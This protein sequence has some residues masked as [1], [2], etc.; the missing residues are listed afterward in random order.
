MKK[1]NNSQSPINLATFENSTAFSPK[2]AQGHIIKLQT[3]TPPLILSHKKL[4]SEDWYSDLCISSPTPFS[5][6]RKM[7]FKTYFPLLFPADQLLSVGTCLRDFRSGFASELF[8]EFVQMGLVVPAYMTAREGMTS[9]YPERDIPSRPSPRCKE[10]TGPALY[11]IFRNLCANLQ[12][13]SRG[14]IQLSKEFRLAMVV[15]ANTEVLEAWFPTHGLTK[16]KIGQMTKAAKRFG[17]YG[18][19]SQSW[20]P[21]SVPEG[22][23]FDQRTGSYGERQHVVFFD[24]RALQPT[25]I[26]H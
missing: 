10:N 5:Q 14:I 21:Y 18:N 12:D 13:Q 17:L 7:S 4:E 22:R 11:G 15:N 25:K 6:L 24:K 9:P 3:A 26:S 19:P 2:G 8:E 16:A 23:T 1:Q 20:Q